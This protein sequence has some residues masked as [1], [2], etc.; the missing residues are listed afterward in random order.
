MG[1]TSASHPATADLCDEHDAEVTVLDNVFRSL[2]GRDQMTGIAM[3]LKI[4]EDNSLVREAVAEN[5]H[6]KV[7]VVDAGG[8][9]RRAVVGDQLAATACANGWSGILVYGAVRD[10]AI[11]AETDLAVHALGTNPRKTEKRGLGDRDVVVTFC[12]AT[13][14]PGDWI[15]ADLDGV[16][17]AERDLTA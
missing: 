1:D 7:L 9:R 6:G 8:S 14:R 17:V 11:L 4:F 13:I 16:L 2:G 10:A 12:G 15:A 5:G 3:T